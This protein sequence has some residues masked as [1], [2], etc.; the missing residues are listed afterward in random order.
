MIKPM[1]TPIWEI[2]YDD[3]LL[4]VMDVDEDG[5]VFNKFP[6]WRERCLRSSL[7]FT[8]LNK[9][10]AVIYKNRFGA[11]GLVKTK[12]LNRYIKLAKED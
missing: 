7:V 10:K 9:K 8:R 5:V 1:K 12:D 3:A 2:D 6:G 4:T 11:R